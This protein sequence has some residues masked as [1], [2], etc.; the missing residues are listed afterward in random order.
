MPLKFAHPYFVQST[1]G[2]RYVSLGNTLSVDNF[3]LYTPILVQSIT[4]P[5]YVSLGDTF[6]YVVLSIKYVL[7]SGQHPDSVS[8]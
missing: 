2:P 8:L 7:Y 4:G 3:W 1:T 6:K 5:R